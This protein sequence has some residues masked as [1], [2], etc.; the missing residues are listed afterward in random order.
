[1]SFYI[2]FSLA[3]ELSRLFISIFLI[4]IL[5]AS[6]ICRYSILVPIALLVSL[7]IKL[8]FETIILSKV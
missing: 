2:I 6:N 5:I 8:I 4:V 7:A 1:M 3:L